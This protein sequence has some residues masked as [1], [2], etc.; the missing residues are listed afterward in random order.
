MLASLVSY[1]TNDPPPLM[2]RRA[3]GLEEPATIHPTADTDQ[4]AAPATAAAAPITGRAAVCARYLLDC[5]YVT[6]RSWVDS[7]LVSSLLVPLYI[8]VASQHTRLGWSSTAPYA[9]YYSK[10]FITFPY[11]SGVVHLMCLVTRFKAKGISCSL[12]EGLL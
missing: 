7:L 1:I 5:V 8:A 10:R 4:S 12:Y 6:R 11:I 3:A 2:P 9:G